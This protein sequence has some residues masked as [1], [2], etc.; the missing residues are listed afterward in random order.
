MAKCAKLLQQALDGPA[1]LSFDDL[2]H[3]AECFGFGRRRQSGTSH[4]IY[5][6]PGFPRLMNFQNDQGK[7]KTYQVR[8]LLQA[9]VELGEIEE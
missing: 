9:L 4:C 2:C 1:G 7:A 5:K 3:L 6:R 8:Q